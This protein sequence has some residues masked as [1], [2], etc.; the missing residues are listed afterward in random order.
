MV[1]PSVSGVRVEFLESAGVDLVTASFSGVK[2][3]L[4]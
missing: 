2:I 1:A 3:E 4:L